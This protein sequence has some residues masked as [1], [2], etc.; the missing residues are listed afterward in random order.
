MNYRHAYHAGN[1]ADV[2]KHAVLT[3][4]QG[5]LNADPAPYFVLDTHAGAGLYDLQGAAA[6]K[7]LE[8]QA[9]IGR[10]L[11]AAHRPAA[12]SSYGEA[13]LA[14]NRGGPL[15]RYPGSP[16]IA[17]HGMRANDRLIA[18]E[19]HPEDA[20]TLAK[21]LTRDDRARVHRL[22]GYRALRAFLPPRE[23]RGLILID[24][25]YEVA[26]EFERLAHGLKAASRRFVTGLYLAW[27][28]IKG[29]AEIAAFH[30]LLEGLGLRRL[31]CAELLIREP[32]DPARL[33]GSGLVIANPPAALVKMLEEIL[34]W[35]TAVLATGTGAQFRLAP[36]SPAQAR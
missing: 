23:R 15:R 20:R 12:L 33:N 24:P 30:G 17:L 6:S 28:P 31:L 14:L 18:T 13:I 1:F 2:F 29:R 21:A 8:W 4:A 19:M 16:L 35:L 9:G 7:T 25:P 22:D 26:D 5:A 10:F 3:L 32:C 27:Y 36:L 11:K 34:P